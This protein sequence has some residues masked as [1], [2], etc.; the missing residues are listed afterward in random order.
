M[1]TTPWQTTW[2]L[3]SG[4]GPRG[5]CLAAACDLAFNVHSKRLP[6]GGSKL[7]ASMSLT[8]SLLLFDRRRDK[9]RRGRA[10]VAH[11]TSAAG[12]GRPDY[13]SDEEVYETA[14]AVDE[15]GGLAFDADGNQVIAGEADS[16][17]VSLTIGA[18]LRG[19]GSA[20]VASHGTKVS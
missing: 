4:A 20:A 12:A 3:G 16:R 7:L 13:N 2:R 1:T 5:S 11:M 17:K 10:A 18:E 8:Y 9:L 14:R 15:A 6:Q 19:G